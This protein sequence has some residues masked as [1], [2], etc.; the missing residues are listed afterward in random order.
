[1]LNKIV[2]LLAGLS[3]PVF[4]Q[5]LEDPTRPSQFTTQTQKATSSSALTL[6][7]NAIMRVGQQRRAVINGKVVTEG[8]SIQGATVKAIHPYSVDIVQELDGEWVEKTLWVAKS[9]NVKSNAAE[10]Y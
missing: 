8:Q 2:V 7:V 9:G 5:T 1:M 6:E 4:A 10:N 3:L